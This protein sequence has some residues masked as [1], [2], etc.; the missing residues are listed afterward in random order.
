MRIFGI[1][2]NETAIYIVVQLKSIKEIIGYCTTY[3]NAKIPYSFSGYESS[4]HEK[5]ET[6][7]FDS[8]N[9]VFVLWKWIPF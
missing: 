6:V 7:W 8:E 5:C 3:N 4:L 2:A 1:I 9:K